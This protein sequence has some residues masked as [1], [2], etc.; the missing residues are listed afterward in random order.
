MLGSVSCSKDDPEVIIN[1]INQDTLI[2][3]EIVTSEK[4]TDVISSVN[5]GNYFI[6]LEAGESIQLVDINPEGKSSLVFSSSNPDAISFV[7]GKVT[8]NHFGLST[9]YVI[10]QN[11]II[12]RFMA[13]SMGGGLSLN[14]EKSEATMEFDVYYNQYTLIYNPDKTSSI[15]LYSNDKKLDNVDDIKKLDRVECTGTLLSDGMIS[16]KTANDPITAKAS[17]ITDGK[18]QEIQVDDFV[19]NPNPMGIM[20]IIE[21]SI[22]GKPILCDYLTKELTPSN[23][24]ENPNNNLQ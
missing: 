3:S 1:H 7:N 5:T 6:K 19:I 9:L 16:K 11:E 22:N 24:P 14:P 4:I 13:M 12:S 15:Y 18:A 2:K 10:Y 21:G 17:L 20:I 8:S 23:K